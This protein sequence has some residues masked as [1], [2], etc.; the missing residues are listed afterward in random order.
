MANGN[1]T[2]KGKAFEYACLRAIEE[3]LSQKQIE[4]TVV[5]DKAFIKA[6]T[7]FEMLSQEDKEKYMNAAATA[8]KI[9][10]PL[11]PRIVTPE[12]DESLELRI[13]TDSK[14]KGVKGDVRDVICI[15]SSLDWEVGF[16]CKHNHEALKHPR[17]TQEQKR[18]DNLAV[19]DFGTNWIG[20]P[21][22]KE[23]FEKALDHMQMIKEHEGETWDNAFGSGNE[24]FD[25]A[26]VP[27]L[28]AILEEIKRL[29]EEHE[30]VPQKLLSYFF[31][32]NDFYK[33]ISLESSAQT[34]VV[35]FNMKDTL[36][37][38]TPTQKPI[39]K[40]PKLHLPT[41]LIEG[42]FKEK[43]N[44]EISKTTLALVFDHGWTINMRLH[45]ADSTI[46]ATG[47]KFD[48]QLEGNPHGVYQQQRSWFE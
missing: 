48:V 37:K 23:Y 27:I 14:A 12:Y 11:E 41:R 30:D 25:V 17:L 21:C 5:E 32:S 28:K 15:R 18:G 36:N 1:Q 4:C 20:H 46:K 19:A 7:S 29:C 38:P 24:K 39:N 44:G 10:F 6:S 45:S 43:A 22:S 47:L 13:S 9:I 26:Y 33:I 42:R 16:S 3:A 31:G 2:I 34:K 40:I 8:F 35:A